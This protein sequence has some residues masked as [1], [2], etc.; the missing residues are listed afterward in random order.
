MSTNNPSDPL[1]LGALGRTGE[2]I[3]DFGIEGAKEF[4]K[5]TC[6]PLLEE[7]GLMI[8]TPI[9]YHRLDSTIKML[10][11]AKGKMQI[12]PST[13]QL[14]I[15]TRVAFQIAENA[16]Q[17]SNDTLLE[18]WAGLFASS[19]DRYEEDENIF[20]I[21]ILKSL[22]SSQVKLLTYLCENT[23]KTININSI[24]ASRLDGVV[25]AV[26][27][28]IDYAEVCAIMESN[29]RLKV[30]TE[31]DTLENM[32]LIMKPR[33]NS[34]NVP[35]SQLLRMTM[36]GYP[37]IRISL[38]ALRLYIKCQ[39]SKQ[40]PFEYFIIDVNDYYHN[41]I[42][43][44]IDVEP[45]KTLDYIKDV[46]YRGS[47]YKGDIAHHSDEDF[48]SILSITNES[49]YNLPTTVLNERLRQ[50]IIYRYVAWVG[51]RFR[52]TAGEENWSF[53]YK[54]GLINRD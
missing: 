13:Q 16:S 9:R 41:I 11:K 24:D 15:D 26:E 28:K 39:G 36:S 31:L 53:N 25:T 48:G 29:S 6:K 50:W 17:V 3:V 8:S 33:N 34:Q 37:A 54:D 47:Q 49:W 20:F 18:M 14:V 52:V 35:I 4:L 21:D 51:N 43:E 12:D 7:F 44:Y 40:T 46:A 1:G 38:K 10:E 42:K 45:S 22:T 32:G 19:C 23:D 30:D 5:L 27:K 2:K